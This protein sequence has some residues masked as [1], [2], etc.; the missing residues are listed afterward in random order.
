M[1]ECR[2]SREFRGQNSKN[3]KRAVSGTTPARYR[4]CVAICRRLCRAN[5][6]RILW[7]WLFTV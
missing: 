6:S 1:G 3:G 5:F 7:M 4:K 2:V